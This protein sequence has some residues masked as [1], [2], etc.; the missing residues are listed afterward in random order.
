MQA[1][2]FYLFKC[3]PD[4]VSSLYTGQSPDRIRTLKTAKMKKTLFLAMLAAAT[5]FCSCNSNT[6]NT[7]EGTTDVSTREKI[8][9]PN[10]TVD[11]VPYFVDPEQSEVKWYGKKATDQHTGLV[12]IAEGSLAVLNDQ[13]IGGTIVLDMKSIA[14]SD[15][16]DTEENQK[17]VNHLRSDEFF[18]VD[19]YP[20][21]TF[22]FDKITPILN[23]APEQPN[24]TV[25]GTLTLKD[26]TDQISFPALITVDDDVASA[27]ATVIVDRAKLGSRYGSNT[28]F[29]N[30]GDKAISDRFMIAFDVTATKHQL[31]K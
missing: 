27:K 10:A 7:T 31:S 21:G 24:Y 11:G 26:K 28:F 6:E 1:L 22:T 25:D 14:N 17:L 18:G 29:E 12:N 15:L 13:V 5:T 23:A 20:Q 9:I 4:T 16:T 30:L 8:F 3:A 19:T 2:W